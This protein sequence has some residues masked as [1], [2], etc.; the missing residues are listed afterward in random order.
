MRR[1]PSRWHDPID[2][3]LERALAQIEYEECRDRFSVLDLDI[4]I[5]VPDG[6]AEHWPVVS[7]ARPEGRA[8]LMVPYESL[9]HAPALMDYVTRLSRAPGFTFREVLPLLTFMADRAA[10][11]G[12]RH[13][14]DLH[15][16]CWTT[17]LILDWRIGPGDHLMSFAIRDWLNND[18]FGVCPAG[19][20]S[21][22]ACLLPPPI[23]R[24]FPR[25]AAEEPMQAVARKD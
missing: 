8:S 9:K 3:A 11:H 17:A 20:E 25:E 21:R 6:T 4:N 24:I 22:P 1:Q 7:G 12:R 13:R 15:L 2:R 23:L 16:A 19:E 5:E 10:G 18:P 14:L